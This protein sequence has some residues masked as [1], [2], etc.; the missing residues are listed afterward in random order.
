M[1]PIQSIS[2]KIKANPK[3]FKEAAEDPHH[4]IYSIIEDKQDLRLLYY[5]F[6]KGE[7]K[8]QARNVR[9]ERLARGAERLKGLKSMTQLPTRNRL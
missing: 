7:Y 5:E 6:I 1:Q 4:P 3:I 9:D 8:S 2:N